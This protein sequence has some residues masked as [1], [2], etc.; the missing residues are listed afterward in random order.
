MT[1]NS[2]SHLALADTS[3]LIPIFCVFVL[4]LVL[5][6]SSDAK[7]LE[8]Y[9]ERGSKFSKTENQSMKNKNLRNAVVRDPLSD[10]CIA[11]CD[12]VKKHTSEAI[13]SEMP[14]QD[15]NMGTRLN[16]EKVDHQHPAVLGS[17]T[18]TDDAV[19]TSTVHGDAGNIHVKEEVFFIV[20]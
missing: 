3:L 10:G 18:K 14:R 16:E 12:N 4:L 5:A 2:G 20:A 17:S 1:N 11:A 13:P 9:E 15:F 6:P 7:Q 19:G 8:F